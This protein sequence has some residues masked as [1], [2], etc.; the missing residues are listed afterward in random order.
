MKKPV[1][2]ATTVTPENIAMFPVTLRIGDAEMRLDADGTYHGDTL[3]FAEA[4]KTGNVP[5]HLSYYAAII[6]LI[7][8]STGHYDVNYP[9][10]AV[11]TVANAV[12]RRK[13]R[14]PGLS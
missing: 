12:S 9:A 5:P 13:S 2:I 10:G 8:R 7:I 11:V 1:S 14:A 3:A 6:W 4:M